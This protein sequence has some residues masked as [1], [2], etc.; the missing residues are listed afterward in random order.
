MEI[1]DI[2]N[3][4]FT[5]PEEKK[6]AIENI[7][8][9]VARGEF[10]VVCGHSGCGKTTLFKL[11]KSEIA[12]LGKKEGKILF[13]G[14]DIE[15]LSEKDKAAKIGFVNQNPE[16]Q[17]V[18][19]RVYHELSFGLENLGKSSDEIKLRI[20]EM[21]SYFGI[22]DS[23]NKK[24]AHLSGGQK[25]LVS[26]ASVMAMSPELLILDEPTSQLDP[27]AASDF[28]ATLQKIN[29][30]LGTTVIISEHRLEELFPI[31]DKIAVMEKGKLLIFDTPKNVCEKISDE[32][33]MLSFPTATRIWNALGKTGECPL[34]VRGGREFLMKNFSPKSVIRQESTAMEKETV[35]SIRDVFFR[36]DKNGKDI[37]KGV[38]LDVSKGEFFCL[39]GGNGAGKTTLL[40]I[41]SG[42]EKPYRG[43]IKIFGK[44]IE[45][46]SLEELHRKNTALLPQNVADI[47]I[48][49]KIKDDLYDICAR[50][51]G[52]K[53]KT[54][55]KI[56]AV[57]QNLG[58]ASLLEKHPYDISC[59]EMQKCAIAKLLLTEPRILFLDE[60]TKALDSAAKKDFSKIINN[61]KS[62]GVTIVAVTHDVE[63]AA[64]NADRCALFFEGEVISPSKTE[65]FFSANDFYTTAASRIARGI[66]D[67]AVTAKDIIDAGKCEKIE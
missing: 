56:D 4:S 18:T 57:C 53:K 47:F 30:E 61:L 34:D 14:T 67:G 25:Q 17:I 54:E 36:Y 19:D 15:E 13:C 37:L 65:K 20:A 23:F 32:N 29:R 66:F 7:N 64:E 27:I 24:T 39:L 28:I 46:Y 21:A 9:K 51:Y 60:P 5:Y 33:I 40:K 8:L 49:S 2:K 48:K 22:S 52:D 1:L 35:L 31:A 11:I 45:K 26:L 16:A 38:N 42:T 43:K 59:G 6:C 3:L 50:F 58:I 44:S 55:E 10:I 62:N 41:L 63:F 12:P